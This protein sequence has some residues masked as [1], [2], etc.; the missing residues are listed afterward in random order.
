[1][2]VM[3][4][5][6]HG[7]GRSTGCSL[8]VEIRTTGVPHLDLDS[9]GLPRVIRRRQGK[10]TGSECG[11]VGGKAIAGMMDR[12]SGLDSPRCWIRFTVVG[13]SPTMS[14]TLSDG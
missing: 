8:M 1:M 6:A 14:L 7:E 13:R 12:G 5:P 4:G 3:V 2:Q 10:R 11:R 9:T